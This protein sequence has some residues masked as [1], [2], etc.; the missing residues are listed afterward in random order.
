MAELDLSPYWEIDQYETVLS[1][2]N[3][4]YLLL[5]LKPGG[6]TNLPGFYLPLSPRDALGLADALRAKANEAG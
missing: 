6:P 1:E 5:Q 4:V 2:D 3:V